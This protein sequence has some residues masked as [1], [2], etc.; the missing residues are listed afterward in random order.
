[1]SGIQQPYIYAGWGMVIGTAI[2]AGL[3]VIVLAITG[4]PWWMIVAGM[5]TGIGLSLGASIDRFYGEHKER[6]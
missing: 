2:G 4:E 3:G 5:G 6:A 1:M